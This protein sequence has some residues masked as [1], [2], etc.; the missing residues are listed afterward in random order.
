[1]KEMPKY[2]EQNFLVI[3]NDT[4]FHNVYAKL[5]DFKW[6]VV[7]RIDDNSVDTFREQFDFLI[8]EILRLLHENEKNEQLYNRAEMELFKLRR[9][10]ED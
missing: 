7:E 8:G 4:E 6:D 2:I 5:Y 1:M 10:N 3:D 9:G